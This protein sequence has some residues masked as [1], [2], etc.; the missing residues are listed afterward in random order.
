MKY[1]R[2]EITADWNYGKKF[3]TF[4][5]IS[6]CGNAVIPIEN[7]AVISINQFQNFRS[8]LQQFFAVIS[9]FEIFCGNSDRPKKYNI[10]RKYLFI[11]RVVR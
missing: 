1:R 5:V 9:I 8:E 11:Q 7:F 3:S 4:A 6:I 2:I 10:N